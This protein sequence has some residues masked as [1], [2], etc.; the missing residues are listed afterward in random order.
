MNDSVVKETDSV[1]KEKKIEQRFSV[2]QIE[3]IFSAILH[4]TDFPILTR[5]H[6]GKFYTKQEWIDIFFLE[7]E[8][9]IKWPQ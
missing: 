8:K 4:Y 7:L 3:S 5:Q 2:S 1:I 6:I 9:E